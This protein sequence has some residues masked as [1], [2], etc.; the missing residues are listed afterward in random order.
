M[1]LFFI[2]LVAIIGSEL[3]LRLPFA[4]TLGS[5][6]TIQQKAFRVIGSRRISDHWKQRAVS[7][8]S[9]DLLAGTLILAVYFGILAA[10]VL[11]VALTAAYFRPGFFSFLMSPSGLVLLTVVSLVYVVARGHS[12]GDQQY[13]VFSRLLH[14]TALGNRLIAEASFDIEQAVYRP[15]STLTTDQKHIFIAGLARAGTTLLMRRFYATGSFISLTYRSMPFVL[16][17][18]LWIRLWSFSRRDSVKRERAHRDG[19]LIDYDSPEALEEVFWRT[20]AGAD[21]IREDCLVSMTADDELIARF[22]SYIAS[23]LA[24]SEEKESKRYLSKNNNNI[25]RLPAIRAAFPNALIIV[26]FR[27][28]VQQA[29]SLL[30]VHRRFVEMQQQDPF[31]AEYMGWLVHREFGSEHRPF[32]FGDDRADRTDTEDLNY[33]LELWVNTYSWLHSHAPQSVLF[34]SY[35]SLCLQLD[36]VWPELASL[37]DV[38]GKADGA[39][40]VFLRTRRV[41]DDVDEKLLQE[42][43]GVYSLLKAREATWVSAGGQ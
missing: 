37:A 1:T 35:E 7:R 14:R 12:G 16:M 30:S 31:V 42:A 23:L 40:P 18:N 9:I 32:R 8:Y 19:L 36:T 20:F 15:D 6:Y 25:L 24:R 29:D 39:E 28:P 4:D 22:R 5:I 26:P 11:A 33:W 43:R 21:Y 3:F 27:D 13:G 17:P 34:L 38:F 41:E 10:G 2:L